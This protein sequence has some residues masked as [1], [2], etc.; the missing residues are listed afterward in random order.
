MFQIRF[1]ILAKFLL[2]EV[3]AR[4]AVGTIIKGTICLKCSYT[5][6]VI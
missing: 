4:I 2:T 1:D 3:L 5:H 6:N